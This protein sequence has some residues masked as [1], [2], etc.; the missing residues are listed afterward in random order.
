MNGVQAAIFSGS[1]MILLVLA[2]RLFLKKHLPRGIFPAL[3]CLC[4]LRMLLPI[5]I[6]TRLSVWN[7]LHTPTAA[8]ANGV[9]SDAL[10]PFPAFVT[11]GTAESAADAA[12]IRPMLLVWLV[13]AILFAAYFVIGYACMVRRFRGTRLAPQPSIDTLLDRFRFSRDPHICVSKSRRAPLTF[14]VFRP[15][16]LLPEDLPVGDAQ[17]QLVLAHELAHIRR[18][19]CLRKLLLTVCLCLYWWNPLVW[20]MVWLAN[21]DMELA[22]DEAVLR[23]LGPDC[24]K[25]YALTLLDMAQ[26]NPKS[27]PLCSGFAKSGTEERI[28]A[29]LSFKRIPAWVGICVAVLFVLTASVFTTQAVSLA[30]VPEPE[31]AVQE[32]IPEE[33]V[34]VSVSESELLPAT[35]PIMPEQE[36]ESEIESETQTRSE[37]C[38]YIFPL[39]D[40]SVEVTNPYGW[41]EHPVT[42][43]KSLHSGVDLAADYG[44]NVLA[45][46]DGTVLDCSYDAAF[47]YI[48]TLEHENGV[49]TQYAHLSEFLVEPGDTVQQ[50]QIIAKTGGSGWATGPHLH[51]GVLIDG[52]AVDPL[53]ALKSES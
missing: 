12:G 32:E 1:A 24:R 29:I 5:T 46:A 7:L 31:P 8:Q 18:K 10:T 2:L 19:D 16:V 40:T 45:V 23:A 34:A 42:K 21:R 4:A 51:L 47:G 38:A 6:P 14:G 11:N 37:V 25:A 3:W 9:I 50:G 33:N 15:T 17:F 39:E 27:A 28:C 43:Q 20:L 53:E 49:Q 13:C 30:A 48:L 35:P 22:C 41:Q 26:R 36:A 44:T 52:E